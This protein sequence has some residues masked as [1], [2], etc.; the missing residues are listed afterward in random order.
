M[1]TRR[2]Q[3]I[4]YGPIEKLDIELPFVEQRPKPVVVVGENGSGKS[5]L[6]SHIVNGLL[7][8]KSVAFPESPEVD[9]HKVYKLRSSA[10][11]TNGCEYSFGRVDFDSEL[12]ISEIRIRRIKEEY[13]NVPTGIVGTPV[14]EGW[15]AIAPREND[16][17]DSNISSEADSRNK[18]KD[19]FAKS[20][21]LYFPPN[22]FEEPAWLNE[23]NL[24]ARAQYMKF[25]HVEGFTSRKVIDYSPL[26]DN[27][28]WLFDLIYDRAALEL[29]TRQLNVP[30]NNAETSTP[31][32][33]F[34]GYS[35]D[36]ART[37]D[38]AL[39]MVRLVTRR[40][41]ARFGIGKRNNRVV[42]LESDLVGQLVPNIFQLSSGETS[43]LNLFL[44]ILRDFDLCGAHFSRASDISGIVVVDEIDLHLHAIQ[45]YEIL[46]RLIQM[47]P[48]VQFIVTTHSPLFVLGMN[49]AFGE[50]GFALY[51]LPQ[52]QQISP[53]EFGEFGSAYQAFANTTKFSIDVRKAIEEASKPIVFVEGT[54]DIDYIQ[55]AAVLLGKEKTLEKVELRDGNG[56]ANLKKVW[57][58]SKHI[59]VVTQ[60]MVLIFDCDIQNLFNEAKG[61]LFRRVIPKRD[62]SPVNKGIENLFGKATL[63][64]ARS[65]K[66]T[67]FDIELENKGVK[68]GLDII[69]PEKW[70]VTKSE[71]SNLCS[72]LCENGIKVDFGNFQVIFDLIEEVLDSPTPIPTATQFEL[73]Q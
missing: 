59:N 65:C 60:K 35:G 10:Y 55:R 27:Q 42:S 40:E 4:N 1:Y 48:K 15:N 72:W 37:Y 36:A 50:D 13:P 29:Q 32:P 19:L 73:S 51:R 44:C 24:K 9:L 20:C 16:S 56:A 6:L 69:I 45:Q 11:I 34:V 31:L 5:I 68:D 21:V 64:N 2:I 62:D 12:F 61:N 22:R 52:G 18:I 33:I 57:E 28:N 66:A 63:E 46:P 26:H 17:Y 39:Q 38:A 23:K 43:L 67:F 3:L 54:T 53:E 49:N 25:E 8:A 14:E 71:K 41:D 47:F 70:T 30:L 58:T 7:S